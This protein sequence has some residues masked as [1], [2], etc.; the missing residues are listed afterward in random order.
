MTVEL[1]PVDPNS[2]ANTDEAR[3]KHLE[4]HMAVDFDRETL[5]GTA[6]LELELAEGATKVVLDSSH[7]DI[8]TVFLLETEDK[9]VPL[10]YTVHAREEPFGSPIVIELPAP[11]KGTDATAK[12]RIAYATTSGCTGGQFLKPSQTEGKQHGYFLTQC[13]AIHARSLFPVQDTPSLK[14]TYAASITVPA[15]LRALMSALRTGESTSADGK[16]RTYTFKQPTSIPS[17][18]LAIAVGNIEGI[19]VG[20]RTTVF[21]E[22]EVVAAA[23]AEFADTE[24]IIA[25]AEKLVGPYDW[26]RYDILVLPSS[27]PYGGM[28]NPCL[29]FVTPTLLAGDKSLVDVIVHELAHS[30]AGNLVTAQNW[31]H[32]HLNEG[33]TVFLERKIMAELHG[34]AHRHFSARI[35]FK[36]LKESVDLFGHDHPYTCLCPKLHGV[37]PDDS[38]SSIPYE[39]GF[40][41]LFYLEQLLGTESFAAFTRAYFKNFAGRSIN[42]DDFT[43]FLFDFYE[44]YFGEEKTE[45]LKQVDWN[46]WLRKP[47]MPIVE[48]QYD[49]SLA[50]VCIDLADRWDASRNVD[51][52]DLS[53]DFS[54]TDISSFSAMQTVVFLET[55][56]LKENLPHSHLA[57]LDELYSL[58][59]SRNCEIR[60]RWHMI[61]LRA[62]YTAIYPEV[63]QFLSE[64]GRMKYVRPLFRL[65]S[66]AEGGRDLALATFAQVRDGLHPICVRQV[67]KDLGL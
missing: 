35:G 65:L 27:F 33:W 12:I 7:F 58:T 26:G 15:P 30:W 2:F 41:L 38:F 17:Y 23:A 28:E 19:E 54:A 11:A 24:R 40:S 14:L 55:L 25:T 10:K 46:A 5:S 8:H 60:F 53:K 49:D 64:V 20:P 43:K 47:G 21:A 6:T 67:T 3:T 4:L 51:V 56:D 50:R 59:A 66:A 34:E 31:M 22:P 42:T 18:L 32:F 61:A 39:K 29:T 45:L 52:A 16:H 1:C 62:N 44:H 9:A 37:D 36:A 63:A 48:N 57:K 13:Q